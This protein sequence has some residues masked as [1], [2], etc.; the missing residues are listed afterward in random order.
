MGHAEVVQVLMA[1][2]ADKNKQDRVS[3]HCGV[4]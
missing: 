1:S 3:V 4:M 2:G